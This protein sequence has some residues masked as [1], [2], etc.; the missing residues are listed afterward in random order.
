[1]VEWFKALVLKTSEVQ[2]SVGSNPTLSATILP[3]LSRRVFYYGSAMLYFEYGHQQLNY[4][5][6]KDKRLAAV[7]E[8]AGII[9]RELYP[10]IFV[11]L[12]NSI[13]GQ[14]ISRHAKASV[15]R[16]FTELLGGV[17][18]PQAIDAVTEEQLRGCGLSGR[19]AVYIKRLAQKV[20][21]GEID[22]GAFAAM[23]DEEVIAELIKLDGIGKWTAE[24]QLIFSLGRK[25]ILSFGDAAIQNGLKRLY[26]HKKITPALAERYHKRYSPYA[27]VASFYLWALANGD[28]E[29]ERPRRNAE[30]I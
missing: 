24:M 5:K 16:R 25:N 3:R 11:S 22:F 4:L 27:S 28:V 29:Y 6:K 20:L 12:V 14:Q 18:T 21:N 2:A 8:K 23:A 9:Q 10:D 15:W 7:I 26:G 17:V 1:M 19:K 13:A 30:K